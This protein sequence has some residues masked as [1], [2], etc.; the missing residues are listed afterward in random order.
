MFYYHQL[1]SHAA[2]PHSMPPLHSLHGDCSGQC[3]SL[4]SLDLANNY[5]S[6]SLPTLDGDGDMH[7]IQMDNNSFTGRIPTTFGRGKFLTSINL[8]YNK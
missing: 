2:Y 7:I 6:G 8:A 4:I 3:K 5:L 1:I